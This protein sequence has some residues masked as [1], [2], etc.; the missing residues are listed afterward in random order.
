MDLVLARKKAQAADHAT[1]YASRVDAYAREALAPFVL[2]QDRAQAFDPQCLALLERCGLFA[3]ELGSH[4]PAGDEDRPLLPENG[5]FADTVAAIRAL[6]RTDPAAAVLVH[7]HNALV[8]RAVLRFGTAAQKTEWLPRLAG[9]CIGAFAATEAHAGSDLARMLCSVEES[10]DGLVLNG[11]KHWITNARE[12][13]VFLVFANRKPRGSVAVLVP[14]DLPGVRVGEPMPKLSMR[15]SS[16][17]SVTF[18][19][20]RLPPDAVLGGAGGGMDVALYGL[21]CGRIGIAAQ[22]LGLA[23]GAHRLAV[24]YARR[25]Q[26]FGQA[27]F[28]FQ[29]VSFPLAQV[30]AE[31]MAMEALLKEAVRTLETARSHLKV[32]DI[33]NA[34]KLLAGQLAERASSM[35][36][37]T[38]GG[39]GVA[40]DFGVEKFFRDAKVGKIYEGTENI[41]LRA[42]AGTLAKGAEPC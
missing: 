32:L 41:M 18:D 30:A 38:L 3:V 33:A 39:N 11:E 4:L 10:G 7:V 14:A 13:G 26:A 23:E 16:T 37:E 35:A 42:L 8:V 28:E 12:A 40:E 24:A 36:V 34:A 19:A 25:R 22:M 1:D 17:C 29:G 5:G 31:I 15:A 27:I 21:V 20:V 9:G 2:T 6:S